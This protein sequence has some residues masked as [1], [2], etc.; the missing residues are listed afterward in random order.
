MNKLYP[1]LKFF[2][3]KNP[4][5]VEESLWSENKTD[6]VVTFPITVNKEAIVKNDLSAI[7]HLNTIK[8]VQEFWVNTTSKTEKNKKD[9]THNVS[10]TV[11]VD[12]NEWDFVIDYLFENKQFF[13][14]VSLIPKIGDKMFNQA[15]LER[16]V[17]EEDEKR[18]Q[19]LEEKYISLDF[20]T[21]TE[22]KD[23]TKIQETVACAGGACAVSF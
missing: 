22:L 6:D 23:N 8:K 7:E 10:C 3:E 19:Q 9:V 17:S 21:L 5:L 2:K 12:E 11:E 1:V 4:H 15:P 20:S 14:A 13:T 18:F 16:V